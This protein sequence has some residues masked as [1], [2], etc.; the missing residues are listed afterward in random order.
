MLYF[1]YLKIN[2]KKFVYFKVII[3]VPLKK[4]ISIVKYDFMK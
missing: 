4:S 3:N 1:I 2:Q